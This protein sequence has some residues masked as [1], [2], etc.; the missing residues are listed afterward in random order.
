MTILLLTKSLSFEQDFVREINSL[1]HEVLSSKNLL[2][3][4][5]ADNCLSI[6]LNH[7]DTII[8]SETISDQEVSK[9]LLTF[10]NF[11]CTIYRKTLN[12]ANS[13]T[14]S[15][16]KT[17]GIT[18]FISQSTCFDELR[19]K[20]VSCNENKTTLKKPVAG[21][22][23]LVLEQLVQSFSKQERD[24]FQVLQNSQHRF[25]TREALSQELWGEAPTKSK[26]SRL[27]GIIRS[28]KRKL[29]NFGFD[30]TC[31]ETSWGRGYRIER[32][33]F[34]KR[35]GELQGDLKVSDS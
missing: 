7:F 17:L 23:Q 1:G 21:S 6:D 26:E 27:S 15:R 14:V 3:E 16:W 25:I 29:S 31:L 12:Q 10:R 13:D 35:I 5:Q 33:T 11:G 19:E 22:E 8:L 34:K 2:I 28:I 24:V 4:L 9:F 32:L 18:D 30:E 20:L